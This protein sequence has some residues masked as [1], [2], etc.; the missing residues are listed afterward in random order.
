MKL[1]QRAHSARLVFHPLH[2]TVNRGYLLI[3]EAN[4][5]LGNF[6]LETRMA[7][8]DSNSDSLER[9]NHYLYLSCLG[10]YLI[11]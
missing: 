7:N 4:S 2:S 8:F 6:A 1:R 11:A 3:L 10:A 9:S 5:G